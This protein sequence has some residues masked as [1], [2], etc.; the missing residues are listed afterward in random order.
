MPGESNPK[1][2]HKANRQA[3]IPH[4]LLV[5]DLLVTWASPRAAC[6]MAAGS[7]RVRDLSYEGGGIQENSRQ[8]LQSGTVWEGTTQEC[9]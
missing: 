2:I 3:S 9:E 6:D 8:K 1:V 4:W 5:A 7:T